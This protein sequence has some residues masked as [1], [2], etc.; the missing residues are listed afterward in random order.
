MN[1]RVEQTDADTARRIIAR[2]CAQDIPE[3]W[4][5]NLGIGL[6]LLVAGEIAPEKEV[7]F[8]SENGILG[9]GPRP[10]PNAIDPWM[11][12][13]GKQPITLVKGAALFHH[14]D[15]FGM[16]RG[17]HIDL[18]ILGAYQV[19]ANGDV[20]NWTLSANDRM[21]AVGGAMD[22]AV[23]ARNVWVMMEHVSKRG[24][25]KL[26]EA[27]TLPLTARGVIKRIYTD[28]AVIDVTPD[29]YRLRDLM[30]GASLDQVR[31]ATGAEV[32]A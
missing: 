26:V 2:R 24:E 21:P 14:A 5:V 27:C 29:G 17:G 16:I 4:A 28:L 7:L 6:P 30:P 18:C 8:H 20:A 22:L 10:R 12:N 3:G 13:A 25:P 31:H 11:T 1:L 23:G 19:A 15:S 9:M 32:L